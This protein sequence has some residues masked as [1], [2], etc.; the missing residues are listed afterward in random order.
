MF[1]IRVFQSNWLI[2]FENLIVP[3]GADQLE[4][5]EATMRGPQKRSQQRTCFDE[6]FLMRL[7]TFLL[8]VRS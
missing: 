8:N 3:H 2:N 4:L 6:E 1:K 7:E 5:N